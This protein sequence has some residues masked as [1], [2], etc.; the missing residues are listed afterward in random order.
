MLAV[1]QNTLVTVPKVGVTD[2]E[3]LL[4]F[5]VESLHQVVHVA[6]LALDIRVAL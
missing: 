6:S 4:L 1:P 3:S 2:T 5:E